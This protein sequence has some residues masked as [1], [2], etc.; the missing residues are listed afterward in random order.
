MLGGNSGDGKLRTS[1]KRSVTGTETKGYIKTAR[2]VFE[3][4]H[5]ACSAVCL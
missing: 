2:E 1:Y 5:V 4:V 3:S